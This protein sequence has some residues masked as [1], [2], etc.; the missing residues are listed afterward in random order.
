[1]ILS[2]EYEIKKQA[3]VLD[4][5]RNLVANATF[6]L[7]KKTS[8][9]FRNRKSGSSKK[10][11]VKQFNR[12]LSVDPIR[13]EAVVEGMTTYED[14]VAAT[15][16]HGCLPP[17]VPELKTITVGG[18]LVG[19]GIEA[20]SF[21]YGLVHETILEV[22]VLTGDGSLLI[23]RPDNEYK[24]LFFALP[25]SYGT[26]GYV[27]KIK[28][29]LI[30]AK[31]FVRLTHLRFHDIAPYF[32]KLKELCLKK[33]EDFIDGV[34]FSSNEMYIILGEFVD[35]APY[36]SDYTYMSA[37]FESLRKRESNYLTTH[38]YIWRWDADWFWCSK[39][40]GMHNKILR[41]LF[42]KWMLHSAVYWKIMR[43]AASNRLLKALVKLFSK[44]SESV[45][46]DI[47]IPIG[48]APQFYD[49]FHKAI[50][51]TPIWICPFHSPHP[52]QR[53]PLVP[54][55]SS[56]LYMDFGFW[57]I[58]PSKNPPGT[59]NRLIEKKAQELH[60][61]KSLYSE[62]FYSEEEFWYIHSKNAFLHLK[63]KY[64][65]KK[66]FKGLYEKCVRR[67]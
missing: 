5:K 37:Y 52:E 38:D 61:Y 24:D 40:F 44:P 66:A 27:L 15:L 54:I 9:L 67:S 46:Q 7:E 18:A 50:G 11:D 62:S 20:S 19:L 53:Y 55:D 22:E 31:K 25:N 3:I 23:S 47:L 59:L 13:L 65:P 39:H 51:I 60:G 56:P 2:D 49:F 10:L 14:L 1:M 36:T 45:I 16:R 17:V 8:N 12:V 58:V 48:N 34:I 21:R 42:G 41:F 26:L 32:D 4:F 33:R 63:A 64:D 6:A 28:L 29:K 43:L 30:P 35:E 57:D